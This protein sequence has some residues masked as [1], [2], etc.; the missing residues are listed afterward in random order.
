M[1]C[2][3]GSTG[4]TSSGWARSPGIGFT[5][6]IFV[7]GLAYDDDALVDEAKIGILLASVAAAVLGALW[8]R[9]VGH[10]DDGVLDRDEID[11]TTGE[12]GSPV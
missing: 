7:A 2:Q 12:T 6:A 4:R 5:V 9:L 11:L 8:L 10:L 1:T 3:S